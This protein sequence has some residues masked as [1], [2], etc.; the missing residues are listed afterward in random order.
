V[1]TFDAAGLLGGIVNGDNQPGKGY[2]HPAE[3]KNIQ[4][5]CLP[6]YSVL[7]ALGNLLIKL[8]KLAKCFKK[9]KKKKN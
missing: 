3:R 6:L 5:Q 7:M 1:V 8:T 4:M 2:P 9:K